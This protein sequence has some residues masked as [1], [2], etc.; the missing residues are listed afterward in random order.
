MGDALNHRNATTSRR[1][2]VCILGATGSIGMNT[3]DVLSRHPDDFEVVALT[4]ASRVRGKEAWRGRSHGESRRSENLTGGG[5]DHN[6]LRRATGGCRRRYLEI[7]AGR[8]DA[9]DLGGLAV[10]LN[11]DVV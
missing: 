1:Q 5:S 6:Y 4:G 11:L 9:E 8:I 2:R 10:D 7:D 3:L